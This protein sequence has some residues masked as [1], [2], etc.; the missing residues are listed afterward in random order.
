MLRAFLDASVIYSAIVSGEGA[1]RE[2]LKRHIRREVTLVVSEYVLKEVANNMAKKSP[3][4]SGSVGLLIDLLDLEI[5]T[6]TAESVQE[7]MVYTEPKDA[8][9]VAAAIAG[10]CDYLLT[11]DKKHLLG[12][13]LIAE[14]A[15]LIIGTPGDLLQKLNE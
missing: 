13:A 1:S 14:N 9:V 6:I 5:V 15:G 12:N 2:L 11:Y 10:Q 8:P 4:K 3:D 7:T